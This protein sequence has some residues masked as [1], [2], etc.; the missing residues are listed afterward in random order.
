MAR[1]DHNADIALPV[2]TCPFARDALL[3]ANRHDVTAVHRGLLEAWD[4]GAALHVLN[5]NT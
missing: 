4:N 1:L 5:S 3:L 2:A